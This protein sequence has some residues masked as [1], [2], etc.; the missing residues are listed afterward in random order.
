MS[1]VVVMGTQWGDEGK[2]K[3]VDNLAE[4]AQ[5]VVRYQGGNNAGHTVVVKGAELEIR[6]AR[7]RALRQLQRCFQSVVDLLHD[8]IRQMQFA[9]GCLRCLLIRGSFYC[10]CF[11]H[12]LGLDTGRGHD[13][14]NASQC[15]ERGM[16]TTNHVL[17]LP[18]SPDLSHPR[19]FTRT[20]R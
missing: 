11:S 17:R 5:V 12:R 1:S 10:R 14:R 9:D 4:Q 15:R 20:N 16:M 8:R 3:I 18:W 13:K 19:G 6:L 7:D 2:G